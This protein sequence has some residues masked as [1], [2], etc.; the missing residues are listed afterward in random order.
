MSAPCRHNPKQ[1]S[2]NEMDDV[3]KLVAHQISKSASIIRLRHVWT[4][5][6]LLRFA[7]GRFAKPTIALLVG[8]LICIPLEGTTHDGRQK[9]NAPRQSSSIT[10]ITRPSV[11]PTTLWPVAQFGATGNVAPVDPAATPQYIIGGVPPQYAPHG[12]TLTFQLRSTTTADGPATFHHTLDP[13]YP[14][15]KGIPTLDGSS[16]VFTYTPAAA[17]KFEFR[18]TF[19]SIV[20]GAIL[21]TQD[22]VIR[23]IVSLPAE[24][25]II[26]PRP[27]R[28]DPRSTDY[29]LVTQSQNAAPEAF[30]G[31]QRT[32]WNVEV[33]GKDVIFESHTPL[34]GALHTRFHNRPD[35]K[36]LSIYAETLTIKS[37]LKLP[38]TNVV[39]YA[40]YLR[41]EDTAGQGS[42][43]TTPI[44]FLSGAGQFQNGAAG[45][46]G[47]NITLY[48]QNFVSPPGATV[49]FVA[50]G[51]VGQNAGEGRPGNPQPDL[52]VT[53]P[54][55]NGRNGPWTLRWG[56]GLG[57][58]VLDWSFRKQ[59]WGW[60][61]QANGQPLPQYANPAIVYVQC[62]P[63]G[64]YRAGSPVWPADGEN[65]VSP[66]TPGTGGDGGTIASSRQ[67]VSPYLQLAGGLSGQPGSARSGAPAQRPTYSAWL[68]TIDGGRCESDYFNFQ[69]IATHTSV[70]G[71]DAPAVPP[72][73]AQGANGTFLVLP[74][75]TAISWL[76]PNVL[77]MVLAHAKD[78][79]RGGDLSSTKSVLEAYTALLKE[80]GSGSVQFQLDFQ[81]I[82]DEIQELLH[83]LASNLDYFGHTAGWVPLLSLE[84]TMSAFSG[85]VDA[86]VPVLFLSQWL[87][88]KASQNVKDTTALQETMRTLRAEAEAAATNVNTA[89]QN[90]PMLQ[91]KAT[92]LNAE[93]QNIHVLVQQRESELL[94][95]AQHDV[96][97]Q[98]QVP[99]WKKALRVIGTVASTIPVY[100]PALG[101]IGQGLSYVASFDTSQPLQSLK[102][103]PDITSLFSKDTWTKSSENYQKFVDSIDFSN[104]K[105]A[106]R[107]AKQLE[108]VYKD[109]AG[110][111][112]E[113]VHMLQTSQISDVDVQKKFEQIAAR[114]SRFNDL[115][116]QVVDFTTRKQA[117][118]HVVAQT[119][120]NIA[121]DQATMNKDLLSVASMYANLNSTAA[122][123]DHGMMGYIKDM[124]RRARERLL[125]YH[126]YMAKAYE[127]RMLKPFPGDL[128][129][130]RVVDKI[131][132]VMSADGYGG[133]TN[134]TSMTAI[135]AV[136]VDSVRQIISVAL[137]ELQDTPPE[138]SLPFYFHLTGVQLRRL[139]QT[140][141]VALNLGPLIAGLPN[142]DNRHIADFKVAA[143][144]VQSTG[145]LGPA[146]RVRIV[147]NHQGQSTET[148]KG[149]SYKFH[150]GN[151]PTDQPFT[152][153]AS[154]TMPN[155]P[156][157]QEAV[158]QSG[159]SLLRALLKISDPIDALV[160]FARPGADAVVTV[161]KVD[162][163]EALKSTIT[164]LQLAVTVDFF[165][166]EASKRIYLNV[167]TSQTGSPYVV[168]SNPDLTGR[169]DGTGT[170]RRTFVP[171][172]SLTLTAEPR[173]GRLRF[174]KWVDRAGVT[175]G[176]SPTLVLSMTSDQN[177]QAVYSVPVTEHDFDEDGQADILWQHPTGAAAVWLLNGVRLK[178]GRSLDAGAADGNVVATGDFNGDGQ[179]DVVWQLPTGQVTVCLLQGTTLIETLSVFAGSTEWHVV[180]AGDFNLDGKPDLVWQHPGGGVAVWLL[181]GTTRV[182][183]RIVSEGVSEWK[184]VGTGD[185]DGDGHTDLI[186]QHPTGSLS[187]WLLNGTTRRVSRIVYPATTSWNVGG[188][189]DFNGDG[190]PD[191][192]WQ[193]P[194][195]SVAVWLMDGTTL[196]EGRSVYAG[197]TD[198]KVVTR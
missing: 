28:P 182:E 6:T 78:L 51:G 73:R 175:L 192:V 49:R 37:P 25:D 183:G 197:V 36:T 166:D 169:Q 23:P 16:G 154:Y 77:R 107:F 174:T 167:Q 85:E 71:K 21:D 198:W 137:T 172:Q 186:W 35:I 40:R 134:P 110:Q 66:G 27:H 102:N 104:F 157:S 165:R 190:K 152:W 118:A 105:D 10:G 181:N 46:R 122:Q 177:V 128:N 149:R 185:F 127:Y 163:P 4:Q 1:V 81:Q 189:G 15:P 109:H 164:S 115:K 117:F 14:K 44:G 168:V 143:M 86:A 148:L 159:L 188:T 13:A 120:Q 90:I 54:P 20:A 68:R 70:A 58:Y 187:A 57:R 82:Q 88:A 142:E 111:I 112:D 8:A 162:A 53:P 69:I 93:L 38:G 132:A 179:L 12:S 19:L 7:S 33:S 74:D 59:S 138:R 126:Y 89:L 80:V 76:H 67:D 124:D 61:L 62:D 30:N 130:D 99:S 121:T 151:D 155:G 194:S 64:Q 11:N 43:E 34:Y 131:L 184:V 56:A 173:Y 195:G 125:R 153:G 144:G 129:V 114:D 170:F 146:A 96:G 158:S 119:L 2:K 133:L 48:I 97:A 32:T 160:L 171:G 116:Q 193:H 140:G 161:K 94:A 135:K 91:F 147:I 3:M 55:I 75:P 31:I 47:G 176:T 84:A 95:Q 139:N 196:I 72:L 113:T 83:R 106:E 42:L 103:R 100:Q 178:E 65:A 141:Q 108:Q 98:R 5:M 29:L 87:Q 26:E 101:V 17:D 45:Q 9:S 52:V 41:F 180:G 123:F 18:V 79:Y 22:V 150:F 145:P 60:V 50:R 24:S 92:E 39:I 136:Y 191:I 63:C 156:L